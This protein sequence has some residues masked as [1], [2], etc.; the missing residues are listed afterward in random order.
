MVIRENGSVPVLAKAPD[1]FNGS[2]QAVPTVHSVTH[3][4]IAH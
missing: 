2:T 4:F 1:K 3:V